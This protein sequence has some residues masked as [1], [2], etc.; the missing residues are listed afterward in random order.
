MTLISESFTTRALCLAFK[1]LPALMGNLNDK[2]AR[3]DMAESCLLA[4]LA[5]SQT[6]TAVYHSISYP[7][8]AHFGVPHGL[9]CAFTMPAVLRYNLPAD[10]GRLAQLASMLTDKGKGCAALLD[11]FTHFHNK[12]NIRER[13]RECIREDEQLLNLTGEMLAPERAGNNLRT[14]KK[15]DLTTVMSQAI[16]DETNNV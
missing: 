1:A 6:R 10:D 15:T 9:A 7:I 2:S 3:N 4:G 13:V 5:I 16:A 8:T 14:V 11:F 12:L